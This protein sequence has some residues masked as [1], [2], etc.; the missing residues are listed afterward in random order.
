VWPDTGSRSLF[1]A[2]STDG[3]ETFTPT[4]RLIAK[5]FATF[6]ITIPAMA[7]RAALV[8]V[9]IAAFGDNVYVSWVDLSGDAGC[10]TPA[11]EPGVDV[12]SDCTARIWFARSTDA[13]ETWSQPAKINPEVERTDQFNQRLAVDPERGVLGIVYYRTGTGADRKRTNLMFQC[14]SDGGRTWSSPATKVTTAATDETLVDAD[15]GNQ[16]GDYNGLSVAG[17]VFFPSWTDRRDG[18]SESIFTAKITVQ[19]N[20][21]GILEAVVAAAPSAGSPAP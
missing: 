8:G 3:G 7:R 10:S 15:L 11:S 12:D 6:Q 16:Y 9:S 19:P 13:G 2:K 4:P 18:R 5:T 1:F 17:T 14:S 20:A 21:L